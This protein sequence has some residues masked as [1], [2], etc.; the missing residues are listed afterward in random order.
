MN[1]FIAVD[2]G[3]TSVSFAYFRGEKIVSRARLLTDKLSRKSLLTLKNKFPWALI[4]GVAVAS[5]VPTA[6]V[7]LRKQLRALYGRPV[8]FIGRDIPIPINNRYRRPKEVGVDRL[9][10][11]LAAYRRYRRACI[12][13]DFGTAITF[14]V[15][16]P[17]GEYLGGIIAP[18]IEISLEALFERTALLPRIRLAAPKGVIGRDT[19]ESIRSGCCYGIG[20]LVDRIVEQVEKS[21]RCRLK[22]VATGGYAGFMSHYCRRI[23]RI[24]PDLVMHGIR[25]AYSFFL[26]KNTHPI[27]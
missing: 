21:L 11:A 19:V 20:G 26:T 24:E 16:S 15:V 17:R 6:G 23:D 8:Y 7:V 13:L 25:A 3:N 1:H 10:D 4:S 5:V 9:M 2:I 12:V 27:K 14:N 22:V 18:G